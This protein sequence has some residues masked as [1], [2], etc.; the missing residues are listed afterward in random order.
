[1]RERERAITDDFKLNWHHKKWNIRQMRSVLARNLFCI[2]IFA[3]SKNFLFQHNA[4]ESNIPIVR[5]CSVLTKCAV[6]SVTKSLKTK[7]F[8]TMYSNLLRSPR[9]TLLPGLHWDN[10][11]QVRKNVK[12]RGK[13]ML[14]RQI[15]RRR[16]KQSTAHFSHW[17]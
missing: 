16:D 17:L 10:N 11:L 4:I 15:V 12:M 3:L 8:S 5:R 2:F 13:T 9:R 7:Y 14:H 1:M 6:S